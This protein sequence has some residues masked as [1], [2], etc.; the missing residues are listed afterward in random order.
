MLNLIDSL[1]NNLSIVSPSMAGNVD[2]GFQ[3]NA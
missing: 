3:Y 1:L 2:D